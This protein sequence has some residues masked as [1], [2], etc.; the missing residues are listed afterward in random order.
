MVVCD[1]VRLVWLFSGTN[2]RAS[3]AG[4]TVNV[5]AG[6]YSFT[7]TM[8]QAQTAVEALVFVPLNNQ[9]NLTASQTTTRF[10]IQLMDGAYVVSDTN[11]TVV[12][13]TINGT[14]A[15]Q[16][17]DDTATVQPFAGVTLLDPDAAGDQVTVQVALD[18]PANGQFSAASTAGWTV[19]VA[20]GTYSF[21]GTMAQAQTAVEAALN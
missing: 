9:T 15:N 19:N 11:T 1:A 14:L 6:T 4:W 21:T 7:G 2:T 18:H 17:I 5:A 13:P 12:V 3:T 10:T 16:P 8:A 20:A